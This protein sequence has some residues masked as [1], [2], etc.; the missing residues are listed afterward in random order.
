MPSIHT[1]KFLGK[2]V[3]PIASDKKLDPAKINAIIQ[4]VF[5]AP[6]NDCLKV[7]KFKLF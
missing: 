6:S 3:K 4:D 5:V 7:S 2:P 1:A